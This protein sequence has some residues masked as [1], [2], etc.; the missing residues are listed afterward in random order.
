MVRKV[1]F[2]VIISLLLLAF[3]PMGSIFAGADD[4][5]VYDEA[6][7]LTV[8]E[9][10]NLEELST[11]LSAESE[12]DFII[13][14]TNDTEGRTAEKY[15]EDFYDDNAP[16]YDQ[17]DG[18]TVILAVDM[19]NRDFYI[20]GFKKGEEYLD[21]ER[22]ELVLDKVESDMRAGDYYLAF[23]K[24]IETSHD[25]MR[26]NPGVNPTNIFLNTTFQLI[27]AVVIGAV[28]VGIM[29]FNMGGKVTVNGNTYMDPQDSKILQQRD[30][31]VRESVT[32][33]RKPSNKDKGGSGG[34]GVSSGG[35]SHSGGGRS[36]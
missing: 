23:E 34:G 2:I 1:K 6:G 22:V 32:K 13:L 14:T 28:I 16:G 24:F 21:N 3:L 33:Q 36:F 20:G 12:T 25:Y 4:Q 19:G 11:T 18:N 9:V 27:I 17:P 35:H 26:Y 5:K 31:Y 15:M 10:T 30:S 7:L 29:A 8:D